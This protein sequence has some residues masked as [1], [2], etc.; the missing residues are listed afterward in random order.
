MVARPQ[1]AM[2][3][4]NRK[5]GPMATAA[6]VPCLYGP[7]RVSAKSV[8]VEYP[9]TLQASMA[10]QEH[11]LK[12]FSPYAMTAVPGWAAP[13]LEPLIKPTAATT[14]A[15]VVSAGSIDNTY[16]PKP[17]TNA[18]GKAR[19]RSQNE[20]YKPPH[21]QATD[22]LI[23]SKGAQPPAPCETLADMK[24]VRP[25]YSKTIPLFHPI[26][27]QR[28]ESGF[29]RSPNIIPGAQPPPLSAMVGVDDFPCVPA[30]YALRKLAFDQSKNG[31]GRI[32]VARVVKAHTPFQRPQ[33][34]APAF[35]T[36]AAGLP[37]GLSLIAS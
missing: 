18:W 13:G 15:G 4:Y 33:S 19:E 31:T 11:A 25:L 6:G 34:A 10:L 36:R 1:S 24:S 35:L 12:R 17:L 32:P 28:F 22:L 9:T 37:G 30:D 20:A 3:T 21:K 2:P 23:V 5:Y 29:V 16:L 26:D 7:T 14:G 27:P 8:T